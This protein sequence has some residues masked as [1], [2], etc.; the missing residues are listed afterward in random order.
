MKRGAIG[1]VVFD[2]DDTLFDCTGSLVDASR[3]RAAKALVEHGLPM[4]VEEAFLLQKSLAE[5]Q[6]PYFLVF[7]EIGRRYNLS[8]D[9]VDAAYHAYNSDEVGAIKPFP[10]AEA[11][12][13]EL[14][15][16][17]ILTMLLTTGVYQ[18]QAKKIDLLGIRG[19]FDDIFINDTERGVLVSESLRHLLSRHNLR[20]HEALIVG[21]RPHGEIRAGNE[22]GATTVQ[23]LHGR[24]RDAEPRDEYEVPHYKINRLFQVPTIAGL[25]AVGKPPEDLR[26]VAIGGGTGLP[27]VLQGFKAYA[28]QRTAVVT[29]MD[30]GRSSG[31]LRSELRMLPPGDA[32]NCLVALSEPG[33][34]ER[35]LYELFKYRFSQGS[36][37][38]MSLGNLIIAALT[39]MTGS[40]DRAIRRLSDLMNIRGKVLPSTVTDAHI[41]AE[42]VD[43]TIL[44]EEYNV[45]TVDKPPIKR[46]FLKPETAEVLAEVVDE[47]M[48]AD[49]VILGPGSLFTSV[50]VNLLV[51]G[52]RK[53]VRETRARKFYVC[54]VVTQP[55]QTDGFDAADHVRAVQQYLGEGVLDV[56]ILN[57]TSP[58]KEI[59]ERYESEGARLAAVTDDLRT[60]GPRLVLADLVEDLDQSRVLWEKQDLL[61][62]NPDKLADTIC[63]AYCEMEAGGR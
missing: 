45:R 48:A 29:V 55:G 60:L 59:L 46:V 19:L 11:A 36:F 13:S 50:I 62:H 1:A 43:G 24:F 4:T 7:D 31:R 41:C 6:G 42:L 39:D 63:R 44:E 47:I 17:G 26:V 40:F 20:P 18:R 16:M 51:P 14:R 30:S 61:R 23:M 22:L 58:R 37:E 56:V 12:L 34:R 38:G 54:N 15:A 28:R 21:D 25:L 52:V 9:A 2:L 32:R 5:A 49:I 3:W 8:R 33:R 35:E 27:I 10:D 57:S 53:A